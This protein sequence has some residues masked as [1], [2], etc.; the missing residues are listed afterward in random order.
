M[1]SPKKVES[2]FLIS[3]KSDVLKGKNLPIFISL[4]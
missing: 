1:Y 3:L 2:D 4:K